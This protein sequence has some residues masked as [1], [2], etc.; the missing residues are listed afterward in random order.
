DIGVLDDDKRIMNAV[1]EHLGLNDGQRLP[2]PATVASQNY[3]R[4]A[5]ASRSAVGASEP[6]WRN[7]GA[8]PPQGA[9]SATQVARARRRCRWLPPDS[10]RKARLFEAE[11]VSLTR[12][13]KACSSSQRLDLPCFWKTWCRRRAVRCATSRMSA[14]EG[15]PSVW[16][17]S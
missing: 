1:L 12:V 14:D 11:G 10:R 7:R 5:L 15:V 8:E 16:K 3:V 2:R 17:R 9:A 6:G 13:T 4:R